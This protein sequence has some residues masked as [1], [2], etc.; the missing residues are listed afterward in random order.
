MRLGQYRGEQVPVIRGLRG[1][2]GRGGKEAVVRAGA[3]GRRVAVVVRQA[4]LDVGVRLPVV[5]VG[6]GT[7]A[8]TEH[9]DAGGLDQRLDDVHAAA[10]RGVAALAGVAAPALVTPV[11]VGTKCEAISGH[12]KIELISNISPRTD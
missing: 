8:V 7:A 10:G 6:V 1:R 5:V 11:T 9:G 3:T 2:R 12:T 4:V